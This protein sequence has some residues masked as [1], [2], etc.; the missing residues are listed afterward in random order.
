MDFDMS[1]IAAKNILVYGA[2]NK[3]IGNRKPRN[4]TIGILIKYWKTGKIKFR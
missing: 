1:E 4:M 3:K 2:F